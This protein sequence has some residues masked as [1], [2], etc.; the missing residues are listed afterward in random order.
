MN[1]T[2]AQ[3]WRQNRNESGLATQV[4]TAD[5]FGEVQM[6]GEVRE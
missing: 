3:R 1:Q 6:N 2:A 5:V 4:Y